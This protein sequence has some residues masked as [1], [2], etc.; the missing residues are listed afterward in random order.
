MS[1]MA[2]D[3]R[4]NM[5]RTLSPPNATLTPKLVSVFD[6]ICTSVSTVH[7]H[8]VVIPAGRSRPD[9]VAGDTTEAVCLRR[10]TRHASVPQSRVPRLDEAHR[11]PGEDDRGE[12]FHTLCRNPCGIA[13]GRR[14][15]LRGKV[16]I[17]GEVFQS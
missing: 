16:H 11:V 4:L 9:K 3:S 14:A 2:N 8:G 10:R 13:G 12:I 7:S 6:Q 1:A 17:F 5:A 15:A